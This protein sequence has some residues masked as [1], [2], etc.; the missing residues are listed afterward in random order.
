IKRRAENT[1]RE[2]D[3]VTEEGTL[4]RGVIEAENAEELYEDLR[5]KYDI[6]RKLIWYDEYKNR[7]LCSLALLEEIC[8]MVEGDC[9]GVEE[10]PTSDG[11]EVERWPLE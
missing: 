11:L 5:E 9:Y 4:I 1:A 6:D 10:Y 3:I 7:V 2:S 8:P